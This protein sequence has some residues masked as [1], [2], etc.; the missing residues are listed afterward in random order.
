MSM[1]FILTSSNSNVHDVH[2]EM[3]EVNGTAIQCFISETK[4]SFLHFGAKDCTVI[5]KQEH[6]TLHLLFSRYVNI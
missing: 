2:T 5:V 1:R 4:W 6:Q 3:E